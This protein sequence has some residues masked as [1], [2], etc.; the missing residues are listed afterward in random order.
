[1]SDALTTRLNVRVSKRRIEQLLNP[2]TATVPSGNLRDALAVLFDVPLAYFAQPLND[3][4]RAVQDEVDADLRAQLRPDEAGAVAPAQTGGRELE[5]TIALDWTEVT[6]GLTQGVKRYADGVAAELAITSGQAE[7]LLNL[8]ANGRTSLTI[9]EMADECAVSDAT[10]SRIADVL[11]DRGM[12]QSA[13]RQLGDI[14]TV[15]R[16]ALTDEAYEIVTRHTQ[17][18]P[19]ML[20]HLKAMTP[21]ELRTVKAM[22]EAFSGRAE[23]SDISTEHQGPSGHE[24]PE[25]GTGRGV[26]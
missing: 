13:P 22:L 11:Q 25:P 8:V 24:P 2:D 9:S 23:P 12:L 20:A 18:P 26:A 3:E 6:R 19:Q 1:M 21:D 4:I 7:V 17:P 15:R 16:L 10:A 14:R 5:P